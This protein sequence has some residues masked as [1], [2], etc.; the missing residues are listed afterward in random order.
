VVSRSGHSPS[1]QD[2]DVLLD[3]AAELCRRTGFHRTLKRVDTK[4]TRTRRLDRWVAAGDI[5]I[6]FGFEAH[7]TLVPAPTNAANDAVDD[8][9]QV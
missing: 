5:R 2:A 3:R 8:T 1:L 4:F 9:A 7:L 6:I